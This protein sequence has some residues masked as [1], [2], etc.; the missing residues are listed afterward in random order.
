MVEK[1]EENTSTHPLYD[2][3]LWLEAEATNGPNRN[4]VYGM[5]R[6]KIKRILVLARVEL[7][8]RRRTSSICIAIYKTRHVVCL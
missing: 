3:K 5:S 2:S 7:P 6:I 4:Q 8:A 1:L